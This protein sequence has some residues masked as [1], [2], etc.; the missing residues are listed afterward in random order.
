MEARAR[1]PDYRQR[2]RPQQYIGSG[3]V[4]KA[5]EVLVARRQ[6]WSV[7]T[8]EGLVALRMPLVNGGSATGWR[9]R[10]CR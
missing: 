9:V 1:N 6:N 10:C 8:S 2:R 3:Q 4:E 7:A 5:T